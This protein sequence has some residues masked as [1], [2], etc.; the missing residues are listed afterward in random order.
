MTNDAMTKTDSITI[1][2]DRSGIA[3]TLDFGPW[4]LDPFRPLD[5]GHWALVIVSLALFAFASTA[6]AQTKLNVFIWSEYLDPG[7]VAGFEKLHACKVTVDVYEDAESML[8]KIQ[9]GGVS[10]YDIVVPPDNIVPVMLKL[11]LLA[12][13]RHENLPN[14]R[15]LDE[16]FVNPPYDRG[17]KFTAAYQWGT[18]GLYVRE[19]KGKRLL[20][21]WGL[22]FDAKLQPGKFVMLDTARDTVGAALKFKGHSFN[23]TDPAHLREARDLL[24]EAKKRSAGFEGGVGGRNKVLG[25]G[26][27]AAMAYSGDAARGMGDDKETRY[28]IPREGSIIWVDNLAVPAKAPHRDLAEKFINHLLDAQV[29]ARLSNF[30]QYAT[31]NRAA[32]PFIKKEDLAN[33]AIYPPP[34]VMQKLEFLED[35]GS[36]TP[37]FDEVWTAVKA[38]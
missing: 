23:S 27:V 20:D 21:T 4:T 34:D 7:V 10:L 30:I 24:I 31:P 18:V 3:P 11:G 1:P 37:L 19:A 17:N 36:K 25:R 5:I 8:A 9:G 15:N 28:F 33:P 29:G 12:P 38:R 32:R 22:L 6:S 2:R 35:L 26:A 14:L 13:L 16:R